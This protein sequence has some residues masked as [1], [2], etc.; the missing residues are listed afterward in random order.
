MPTWT[1]DCKGAK[2]GEFKAKLHVSTRAA[3]LSVSSAN[4]GARDAALARWHATYEESRGASKPVSCGY[5]G[6]MTDRAGR[7]KQDQTRIESAGADYDLPAR[8][9]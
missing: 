2:P 8:T 9:P 1:A 5:V 6:W 4:A 3:S 7:W